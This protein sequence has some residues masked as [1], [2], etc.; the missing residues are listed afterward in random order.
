MKTF[1]QF[2]ESQQPLAPYG[3][4]PVCGVMGN[5]RERRIDGNDTCKNGHVYPSADAID[6][7]KAQVAQQVYIKK[8]KDNVSGNSGSP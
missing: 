2:I 5:A 7:M 6:A 4:C 1:N 8:T 3:F